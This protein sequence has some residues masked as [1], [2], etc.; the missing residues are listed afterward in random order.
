M[1]GMAM[2]ALYP[3]LVVFGFNFQLRSLTRCF[4]RL[5]NQERRLDLLCASRLE[6]CGEDRI[7][8]RIQR[9]RKDGEKWRHLGDDRA[10]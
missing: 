10:Q 3:F 9:P 8:I 5:L 6:H 7:R 4:D 2:V 1:Q